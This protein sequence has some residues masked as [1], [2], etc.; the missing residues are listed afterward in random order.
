MISSVQKYGRNSLLHEDLNFGSTIGLAA[1][2]DVKDF[3]YFGFVT[4]RI[5]DPVPSDP[6]SVVFLSRKFLATVRPRLDRKLTNMF[7]NCT[8]SLLRQSIEFPSRGR[9]DRETIVHFSRD[10]RY[11]SKSTD[12]P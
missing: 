8:V 10:A 2:S 5:N 12:S 4:N 11:S 6:N 7:C 1:V 9:L 3:D